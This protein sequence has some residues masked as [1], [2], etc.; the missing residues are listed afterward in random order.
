MGPTDSAF[1]SNN[2]FRQKPAG[3][4]SFSSPAITTSGYAAA[5]SSS[6][7]AAASKAAT[8][9]PLTSFRTADAE[10]GREH[11]NE[12]EGRGDHA[13]VQP[14]P[15]KIVKR[16]RVQSP[17]P[18]SPEDITPVRRF[19]PED[20]E[21]DDSSS[22][23]SADENEQV[24]PFNSASAE[25]EANVLD[26]VRP[27]PRPPPNPFSK[28]L[29]D[30]EQGAPGAEGQATAGGKA[31]M[32]VDSF[33]RLLLTGY[34]DIPS[35][36]GG[37][38]ADAG[39][40]PPQPPQNPPH[41]GASITD[42][43]SISRQSTAEPVQETPRTSHEI[44]EADESEERRTVL[45]LSPLSLVQSA[46]GRKKPP[47][48][49]SRH[50]KLIKL[51]LGEDEKTKREEASS[52]SI[53]TSLH[54]R[55]SSL[56]SLSPPSASDINKPLPLPPTRAAGEE[57]LDSPFDREAAGKL[58]ES[59]AA[60]TTNPRPAT[61]PP[62]TTRDRSGSQ[63]STQTISSVQRRPAAPPPRR[64]G[65]ARTDSNPP[66]IAPHPADEDPPRSS[67]ES[68]RSRTDSLRVNVSS[69]RNPSAP[70]PPPPRRPT[71]SRHGSSLT[72][73][74]VAKFP[75]SPSPSASSENRS[76]G[77]AGANAMD[78]V[79]LGVTPTGTPGREGSVKLSPPPPP[80][81]RHLSTRRT[82]SINHVDIGSVLG[83]R[84]AGRDRE[85]GGAPPPPPPRPRT[86]GSNKSLSGADAFGTS[87]PG[88]SGEAEKA[89]AE[90]AD[91]NSGSG[92]D[93]MEQLKALQ[94]EVEAA[95]K[96]S[97]SS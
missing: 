51:E 30:L 75:S 78:Q 93:I 16:V 32:D 58:P 12:H 19:A 89:N 25:P 77:A 54:R 71:H 94:Q 48:P 8:P 72:S 36:T 46:S 52:I 59:F 43:S 60:L 69:E 27:L 83:P 9:P 97:G 88:T 4:P 15:K 80:P 1:G 96:A 29:Q 81:A 91:V 2:P 64:S 50:G 47:P 79:N 39:A 6:F 68:S 95:R 31:A 84:K 28:T 86:R 23:D 74:T 61:P 73:P 85:G 11:E 66:S 62:G 41:D 3:D 76:P 65:H 38:R 33:K 5:P 13:P 17:P 10:H 45:P 42:A 82:Q 35:P 26:D 87:R 22:L 37:A 53:D 57:D 44:S 7:L 21:S 63:A 90:I 92:G 55:K 14:K 20:D 24:D 18:S 67:L 49:S 34:A 40:S 56:Q 70:A